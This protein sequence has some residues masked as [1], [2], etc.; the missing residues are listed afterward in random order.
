MRRIKHIIS[1]LI[2][3]NSAFAQNPDSWIRVADFGGAARAGSI[4]FSIDSFGYVGFGSFPNGLGG[5]TYPTDFWQYNPY[6]NV[7]IQKA[8]FPGSGRVG[9]ICFVVGSKAYVGLG[10]G[11][12]GLKDRDFWEYDPSTDTWTQKADFGGGGRISAI[13]FSISSMGY[14]GLGASDTSRS[15]KDFWQ[16]DPV[17]N[18]WTKKNNFMGLP[19][20]NASGFN[21]GGNGYV[22][23]GDY[24]PY[25]INGYYLND[26]WMYDTT[27]DTWTQKA[28]YPGKARWGYFTIT[29]G[30]MAYLGTGSDSTYI[31]YNDFWKYNPQTDA[32]IQKDSFG[33]GIRLASVAFSIGNKAY[34]GTGDSTVVVYGLKDFWMYT[35]DSL[36]TGIRSIEESSISIYPDPVSDK[37]FINNLSPHTP[38]IITDMLGQIMKRDIAESTKISI[39]VSALP[40]GVY[41]VNKR[42]FVKE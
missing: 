2:L 13:G 38:I 22:A 40:P 6:T 42:K 31:C 17:I 35:P 21:I 30:D 32:W 26:L 9:A 24:D 5:N 14:A 15:M 28:S 27:S 37:I 20:T 39:D 12:S 3:T 7:W 19:R 41:C 18:T 8:D 29:V 1:L 4:A 34:A 23:V 36:P 11:E 33:G 25:G 10:L 16:Y